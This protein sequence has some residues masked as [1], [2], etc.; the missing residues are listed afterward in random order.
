MTDWMEMDRTIELRLN[1]RPAMTE[2]IASCLI[3]T[4]E[5]AFQDVE[6][7]VQVNLSKPLPIVCLTRSCAGLNYVHI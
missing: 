3:M 1:G 6:T 5:E 2:S 7:S 4:F